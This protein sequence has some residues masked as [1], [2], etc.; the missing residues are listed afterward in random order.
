MEAGSYRSDL[1]RG[2]KNCS[3]MLLMR[4]QMLYASV[5]E[6]IFIRTRVPWHPLKATS[7]GLKGRVDQRELN[8]CHGYILLSKTW[9][10]MS[11][12]VSSGPQLIT[13]C[14]IAV[15][16]KFLMERRLQKKLG[17]FHRWR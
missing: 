10:D 2:D 4:T 3:S 9:R 1:G 17:E 7:I 5:A 16:P 11:V 15:V 12:K 6:C 14:P 8:Y 13:P